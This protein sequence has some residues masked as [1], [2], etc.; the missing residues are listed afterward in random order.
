MLTCSARLHRK[1]DRWFYPHV[2][3]FMGG[4]LVYTIPPKVFGDVLTHYRKLELKP[5]WNDAVP[6]QTMDKLSQVPYFRLS[7]DEDG[8]AVEQFNE[9]PS[10]AENE[11]EF[12]G[13]TREMIEYMGSFL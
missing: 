5:H 4:E 6:Q 7:Y 3:M 12:V 10:L 8:Y 11:V 13:A 9:I 1:E 2:D